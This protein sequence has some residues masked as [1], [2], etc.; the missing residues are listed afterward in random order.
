MWQEYLQLRE[1][2]QERPDL[3]TDIHKNYVRNIF[4]YETLKLSGNEMPLPEFEKVINTGKPSHTTAQLKAYDLWQTWRYTEKCASQHL[5]IDAHLIR[6]IAAHIMKH[7]GGETTTTI[8]RYD[9][10]LGDYRLGEDYNAVYSIADYRQIP[11][12]MDALCRKVNAHLK[13]LNITHMLKLAIDY[14]YAFAHIKPFGTGNLE[15]SLM[16]INYLMLYHLQPL[17][18]IFA[19]DR[20]LGLNAIKSKNMNQTPEEFENFILREQIKFLKQI[21]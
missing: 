21:I 8:G 16:S 12:L 4:L 15:T 17:V 20:P 19:E 10:S 11:E 1:Q 2:Y 5:P 18:I 14:L 6:N 3:Q 9:S 7:T 13:E